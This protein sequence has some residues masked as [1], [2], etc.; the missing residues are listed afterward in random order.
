MTYTK[1]TTSFHLNLYGI[2][3]PDNQLKGNWYPRKY[4]LTWLTIQN[5]RIDAIQPDAF[6]D[7]AFQHLAL[8]AFRNIGPS[9]INIMDGAFNSLKEIRVMRLSTVRIAN[10]RASFFQPLERTLSTLDVHNWYANINLN[11]MFNVGQ[12]SA[13]RDLFIRANEAPQTKFKLLHRDNFTAIRMVRSLFLVDC[14]IE[15][16]D[17]HAF[18]A[19]GRRLIYISLQGNHIKLIN[20][21]MFRK[22]FETKRR[23]LV[24][25]QSYGDGRSLL[26]TCRLLELDMMHCPF[27]KIGAQICIDCQTAGQFDAAACGLRQNVDVR[28]L[29]VTPDDMDA[30][31][32]IIR[33]HMRIT[34]N[35]IWVQTN[36]SSNF[37]IILWNSIAMAASACADRVS[38]ATMKCWYIDNMTTRMDF[39]GSEWFLN[40]E[41]MSVTAIP[42]T[43]NFGAIPLHSITMR[44]S[45]LIVIQIDEMELIMATV[46]TSIV[47]A[48]IGFVVFILMARLAILLKMHEC[49]IEST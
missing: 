23:G 22:I 44:R 9:S 20:I 36:F 39:N 49:T 1:D 4:Y 48:S 6:N 40:A 27:R 35:A 21:V 32:R 45:K 28:Q 38:D 7:K 16:I 2:E 41:Y 11:D 19:I 8:L 14:G 17:E 10:L 26:C 18:D 31:L 47:S 46:I 34:D 42:I 5:S 24:K 13:M 15:V 12:Y 25:V 33:V 3:Y 37:R 29:C 43:F 30:R